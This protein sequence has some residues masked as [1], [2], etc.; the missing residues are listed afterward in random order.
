MANFAEWKLTAAAMKFVD[1]KSRRNQNMIPAS[2]TTTDVN[3]IWLLKKIPYFNPCDIAC[4][5]MN[6]PYQY[7]I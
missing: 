7:I 2:E 6:T 1:E 5:Q 3:N 4:R